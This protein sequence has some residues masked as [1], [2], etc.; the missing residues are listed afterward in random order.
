M[1]EHKGHSSRVPKFIQSISLSIYLSILSRINLIQRLA[2]IGWGASAQ[3][4]RNAV[5]ALV[6]STA[7]FACPVFTMENSL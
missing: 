5:L 3:T 4:L 7:E 2:G 1:E 6:I